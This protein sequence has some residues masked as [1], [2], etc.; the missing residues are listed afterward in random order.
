MLT[1]K[2]RFVAS[3]VKK[4]FQ[5]YI[6]YIHVLYLSYSGIGIGLFYIFHWNPSDG[7]VSLLL[8]VKSDGS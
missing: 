1:M 5:G 8:T 2:A 6:E 4:A 3:S 7:E